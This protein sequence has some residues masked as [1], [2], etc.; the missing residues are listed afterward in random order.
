MA[1]AFLQRHRS[2]MAVTHRLSGLDAAML[3]AEKPANY[4]MHTM[5]VL[6]LDASTMP[7]GDHLAAVRD[8]VRSRIHLVP[9]L[10][11]R[12][13]Q[14]PMGLDV[15]Q[16]VDVP[17]VDLEHHIRRVTLPSPGTVV[18]L[19]ALASALDAGKL[20][21]R[22][23]LWEMYVVEGLA[24][25]GF[26]IV[27]KVH[28]ALMDGIAGMQFMASL[29]AFEPDAQPPPAPGPEKADRAP[30]APVMLIGAL[31]SA[32][33]RPHR[34]V[35]AVGDTL[36]S[37]TRVVR[38]VVYERRVG[39]VPLTAPFSGPH[40]LFDVPITPRREIAFAS[41]PMR[42]IRRV[43]HAFGVTVND[44]VLAVVAGALRGFLEG[45]EEQPQKQLVAAVPVS[46][47]GDKETGAANLVN[48]ML[49]GLATDKDDP[50]DRLSAIHRAAL[51]A[52]GLQSALGPQTILDWLDVPVP[53]LMSLATSIYSRLHLCALHPP[54]CNLVVS[55]VPGPPVA[56]YFAGARLVSLFPLGPIFDGVGLNVTVVSGLET[57]DAGL[58]VCP[59]R[60]GDVWNLANAFGPALDE[61]DAARPSHHTVATRPRARTVRKKDAVPLTG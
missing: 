55:N 21:R 2:G 25:G 14:T 38:R 19:A 49:M 60:L 40:T 57:M 13:V 42:K 6:M 26:C 28:H 43:A 27:A 58:V 53:A 30:A 22:Y 52:K 8:Y 35:I 18:E 5:A 41:L 47:R 24:D 56:L 51:E 54:L 31:A 3:A 16:W 37:G 9:P 20:D 50:S 44:V 10:R 59:D 1:R 4:Y 46:V 17:N 23:P 33:R 29:F 7:P 32:L 12:L 34:A 61:L 11:R 45:R 15:A 48:I 36:R 39:D